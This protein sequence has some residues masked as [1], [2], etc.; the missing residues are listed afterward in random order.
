MLN[1][2]CI[3]SANQLA[4]S[5]D[6]WICSDLAREA[7]FSLSSFN[8]TIDSLTSL[9]IHSNLTASIICHGVS[10]GPSFSLRPSSSLHSKARNSCQII[11]LTSSGHNIHVTWFC[12]YEHKH[13]G[14]YFDVF[15][16]VLM[17]VD[18]FGE[19]LSLPSFMFTVFLLKNDKKK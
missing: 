13:S 10:L 7:Y 11:L 8:G 1:C 2:K 9:N 16:L 17:L 6:D 12:I 14:S 19:A 4:S 18:I 15:G 5:D 3:I